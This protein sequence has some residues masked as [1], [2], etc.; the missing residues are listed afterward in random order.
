[1]TCRLEGGVRAVT[2]VR[3]AKVYVSPAA[4]TIPDIE[5][6]IEQ[7]ENFISVLLG[8]NPAAV[9]R[10]RPLLQQFAG[11][12][13][14]PGLP[15]SL[16]ERRPDV[17]QA[18]SQLAAATARIGVAK[19]D[20]FPRVFL[21]GAAGVGGTWINGSWFGP[22]GLF[23]IGPQVSLPIFYMCRVKAGRGSAR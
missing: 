8:Q 19:A 14:P 12:I 17:R 2:H 7:T 22:T 20:Y 23:A 6:R 21:T 16:L 18:E 3:Q 5:R 4:A 15:S 10:G 9:P 13:V 11:P 1:V